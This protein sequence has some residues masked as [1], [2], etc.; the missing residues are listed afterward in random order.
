MPPGIIFAARYG[1]DEAAVISDF[2]RAGAV[3]SVDFRAG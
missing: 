1:L 2:S 3:S